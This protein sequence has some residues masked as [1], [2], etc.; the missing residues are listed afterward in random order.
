MLPRGAQS[1][2]ETLENRLRIPER[3]TPDRLT[4]RLPHRNFASP[5]LDGLA[6]ILPAQAAGRETLRRAVLDGDGGHLFLSGLNSPE[7]RQQV[8][9][10]LTCIAPRNRDRR[11]LVWAPDPVMHR[12]LL[13][14]RLAAGQGRSFCAPRPAAGAPHLYHQGERGAFAPIVLAADPSPSL[15]AGSLDSKAS[16]LQGAP[17][18]GLLHDAHG[19]FLILDA[20]DLDRQPASL[21]LLRLLLAQ[22]GLRPD[23]AEE[24][25]SLFA[26]VVPLDVR[27]VIV[28]ANGS[29]AATWLADADLAALLRTPV[30]FD[31]RPELD[32]RV[33]GELRAWT[34]QRSRVAGR[35]PLQDESFALAIEHLVREGGRGGRVPMDLPLLDS[36]VAQASQ[37]SAGEE[38]VP[39]E[40]AAAIAEWK[41]RRAWSGT[42]TRRSMLE[43]YLQIP[44]EGTAIGEVNGLAV[45]RGTGQTFARPIR[46]SASVGSGKGGL[47]DVEREVGLSGPS[48]QKGVRLLTGFLRTRFSRRRTLSIQASLAVEQHY[49]KIDGDSASL[50]EL[51]ALLSALAREPL[52]QDI[53]LTGAVDQAGRVLSVGSVTVK[54]EGFYR[55][56]EARGLSGAQGVIVPQASVGDLC[57][58]DDIVA[59][60]AEGRFHLWSVGTVEEALALLSSREVG[61]PQAEVWPEDSLY[62]RIDAELL[63]FEAVQ[64]EASRGPS[65]RR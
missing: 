6:Q 29:T 58:E 62:G 3:L 8:L 27:L 44:T 56:C 41:A 26:E 23:A 36:L 38:I 64:R 31:P 40:M 2:R 28:C 54:V 15:L 60:C 61:D 34:D 35:R 14:R 9:A 13:L 10:A 7:R 11:D 19:G 24:R 37:R 1:R 65:P 17:R 51:C 5:S 50:A 4:W 30:S 47:V 21:R 63:A 25:P 53:A 46:V 48:H 43:G 49:G 42:W 20:D 18:A 52:R 45:Y 39:A 32:L 55:L 33:S 16:T 12:R 57:L 22:G 59:A